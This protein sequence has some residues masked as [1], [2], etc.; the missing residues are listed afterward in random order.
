MNSARSILVLAKAYP[1]IAGGVETYSEQV[2]RGYLARGFSVTVLTQI[3]TAK[4]WSERQYPE[5]SIRIFDTGPG[6]QAVVAMKLAREA[7]RE[8]S[9][10]GYSFVHATTWRPAAAVLGGLGRTPLVVTIH[11]REIVKVPRWATGAM[12]R[13]LER[14]DVV[15]AVSTA[16]LARAEHKLRRRSVRGRWEIAGNGLTFPELAR[17]SLPKSPRASVNFLTIARLVERK[18]VRGSLRALAE[19]RESGRDDFEYSIA[20]TGP[21]RAKLQ[22]EALSLGLE[23]HVRFL[24]YV[25]D[26]EIVQLYQQCDVFVHPQIATDEGADFEGFGIVI[27]DAMSFGCVVVAGRDGGPRDFVQTGVTGMLV[28]GRNEEELRDAL[29]MLM[30]DETL[31]QALGSRG[32]GFVLEHLAWSNHVGTILTAIDQTVAA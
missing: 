2:V 3:G 27:A 11:G 6:N 4:G 9:R 24:G 17:D 28:D 31:R 29:Q 21:D 32:R 20:G 13:I 16:T 8:L 15:I 22:A 12:C 14:A 18:N 19:L 23:R 7:R 1:P 25:S 10:G 26:E 30:R 5:G